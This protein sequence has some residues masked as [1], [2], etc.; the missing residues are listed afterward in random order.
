METQTSLTQ[1][2]INVVDEFMGFLEDKDLD[3]T[4]PTITC[5]DENE[6]D[7]NASENVSLIKDGSPNTLLDIQDDQLLNTMNFLDEMDESVS[8][9]NLK[10]KKDSSVAGN[11]VKPVKD[12]LPGLFLRANKLHLARN[13]YMKNTTE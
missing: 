2:G 10:V 1:D 7:R 11:H 13:C 5:D 6:E 8:S 3:D 9:E 4:L 12:W